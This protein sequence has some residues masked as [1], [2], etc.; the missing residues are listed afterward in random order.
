MRGNQKK[1]LE[2]V[3]LDRKGVHIFEKLVSATT[4]KIINKPTS[5]SYLS[6]MNTG[7][8]NPHFNEPEIIRM[9]KN[10]DQDDQAVNLLYGSPLMRK[11]LAGVLSK[12]ARQTQHYE[13]DFNEI[14][15]KSLLELCKA[16][17]REDFSLKSSIIGLFKAICSKRA[18]DY[19]RKKKKEIYPG[20]DTIP[21]FPDDDYL[22]KKELKDHLMTM[23]KKLPFQ[24]Q[25]LIQKRFFEGLSYKELAEE[26]GLAEASVGQYLK[27]CRSN[28]KELWDRGLDSDY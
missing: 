6:T 28:L 5:S 1:Y 21:E 14:F 13:T 3:G 16:I 2:T 19:F 23:I 26:H 25:Q 7:K 24:C 20:Y 11:S 17:K 10:G 15:H 12:F 8:E 18:I 9:L 22:D 27:R 4:Q